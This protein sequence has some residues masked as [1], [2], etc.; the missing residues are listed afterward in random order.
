MRKS[1]LF[2]NLLISA[3]SLVKYEWKYHKTLH[4]KTPTNT[5]KFSCRNVHDPWWNHCRIYHRIKQNYPGQHTSGNLW[6][7]IAI[8]WVE[9]ISIDKMLLLFLL[10][11]KKL[12]NVKAEAW[13]YDN[14]VISLLILLFF[15]HL[16]DYVLCL[17]LQF[18]LLRLLA[19]CIVLSDLVILE[20]IF[21]V[22]LIFAGRWLWFFCF[23]LSGWVLV[24]WL[25][26]FKLFL[27]FECIWGVLFVLT[28]WTKVGHLRMKVN[29]KPLN[30]M[31]KFTDF[32]INKFISILEKLTFY[33]FSRIWL[34][35]NSEF[36]IKVYALIKL[37]R[38]IDWRYFFIMKIYNAWY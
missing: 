1:V 19:F 3:S 6:K 38:I 29:Y 12:G 10:K 35:I 17:F 13:S 15:P 5:Y 16:V 9:S 14:L 25:E 4:Q 11:L 36:Y 8:V 23:I 27:P 24:Q 22:G 34:M 32:K 21:T 18:I 26:G 28:F 2:F 33:I 37:D 30:K 7:Q 31:Y 20:N